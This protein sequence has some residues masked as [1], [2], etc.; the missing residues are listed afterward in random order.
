MRRRASCSS[1]G[2]ISVR[3]S[4]ILS[5]SSA[6]SRPARSSGTNKNLFDWW[7]GLCFV[8]GAPVAEAGIQS[9]VVHDLHATAGEK[10]KTERGGADG[11]PGDCGADGLGDAAHRA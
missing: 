1:S 6:S 11:D 7:P 2:R 8:L 10:R 5:S 9:K 3:M 4:A